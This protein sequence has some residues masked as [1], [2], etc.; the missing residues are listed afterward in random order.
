MIAKHLKHSI[1]LALS[2]GTAVADPS[3][4]ALAPF[5]STVESLQRY[6]CPEWFR[7]AKFGIWSHW[8]PQCVPEEGD[9]YARNLYIE[10][11]RQAEAH[12][13]KYGHPSKFGYKDIIAL[14][15]A[16][17]FEPERLMALYRKAGAKYFV[18]M[19]V[20]HDNFDLWN[21]RS[22]RWNAVNMGPH[23]D[24]VG[25][26][27]AAAR[28]EGLR[29]GVSEHLERSYSWFNTNKGADKNGPL[30]GVPYDGND[31]QFAD[32]YFSPHDDNSRNYPANPPV[33]WPLEWSDRITDLIDSYHP[34]LLYTDGGIPFGEVGRS[35]AAHF[36]N[37]NM[38]AH[39]G[40]LEAVYNIKDFRGRD[41]EH[42]EYHDGIAVQDLER[43]ILLGIKPEP[44][45][46]DT[47]VA[48][49]FYR[50]GYKYKTATEIIHLLA[51]IVS[52]NGNLLLNFTQHPDGTLDHES[53]VILAELADWT[54]VN[55]EAIF[56]TRP[57]VKFGEGPNIGNTKE[58]F[59][60]GS[61]VRDSRDIRFTT[62]GD[63]I[64]AIILGWPGDGASY[65]VSSFTPEA[66]PKGIA[67]VNLLGTPGDLEW[68]QDAAGL[69]VTFPAHT[70]CKH[71]FALKI[72][73][74][75]L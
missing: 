57:W 35:L 71:A 37:Q 73:P 36:Y 65:T 70:L 24:I 28:K 9:W 15:K 32:F 6:Q 20:H 38:A 53:E 63:V 10:G 42:G 12:R 44:W 27:A 2:L 39:G 30:A 17:H 11:N 47:S 23:K 31:P 25:L 7:D 21:S 55:G 68:S 22:H 1:A 45:Q 13:A 8:G 50:K 19:G 48:D 72:S 59:N 41:Q 75:L 60:E 54:P 29:F 3:P 33:W 62:K 74:K 43:G 56:G 66:L 4:S 5:D 18:S 64:Y 58:R 49:W 26:W 51:D 40:R 61:A 52:K 14:W 34:D 67:R 46:T 69:H 16:E